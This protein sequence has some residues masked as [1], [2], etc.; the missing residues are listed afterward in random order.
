[1]SSPETKMLEPAPAVGVPR[2]C[3]AWLVTFTQ[4]LRADGTRPHTQTLAMKMH[5]SEFLRRT[6]PVL[7]TVIN[8]ALPITLEQYRELGDDYQMAEPNTKLTDR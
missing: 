6:G 8:F 2:P 4:Q 3:S 7:G 1:M 5:P